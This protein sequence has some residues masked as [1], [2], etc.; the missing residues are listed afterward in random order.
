[1]ASGPR[2]LHIEHLV[3]AREAEDVVDVAVDIDQPQP[4][5]G[6]DQTLVC[7]EQYAEAGAGD[8]F[9]SVEVERLRRV[10]GVDECRRLGALGGIEAPTEC[11]RPSTAVTY[12]E[13]RILSSTFR[14]WAN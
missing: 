1:M 9:E 12:L 8:I 14:N 6:R 11:D 2:P 3:E 5:A 4:G 7:L 10:R 13:H